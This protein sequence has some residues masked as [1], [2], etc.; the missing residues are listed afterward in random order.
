[1]LIASPVREALVKC[2]SRIVKLSWFE[3]KT[4]SQAESLLGFV[5]PFLTHSIPHSIFGMSILNQ[6]VNEMSLPTKGVPIGK[7]RKI[8][9]S[10]RYFPTC[11]H[12]YNSQ[13]RLLTRYSTISDWGNTT[14]HLWW[15]SRC[16][17]EAT[18]DVVVLEPGPCGEY[19]MLRLL[20]W[21]KFYAILQ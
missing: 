8:G 18:N 21:E 2:F 3:L 16:T 5:V 13:R 12:T 4:N 11:A 6:L 9:F 19:F 7:Q 15:I 20:R 1:M 10:F 17:T 14:P